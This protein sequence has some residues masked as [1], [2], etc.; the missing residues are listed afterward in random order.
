VVAKNGPPPSVIVWPVGAVESALIA[1]VT[2]PTWR[3]PV[4][5]V[6]VLAPGEEAPAAHV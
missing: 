2:V 5:A 3:V 4:K 1:M 6:S